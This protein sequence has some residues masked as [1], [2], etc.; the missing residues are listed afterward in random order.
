MVVVVYAGT[1]TVG[2][3]VVEGSELDVTGGGGGGCGFAVDVDGGGGAAR[4]PI[5]AEATTQ[6]DATVKRISSESYCGE[7]NKLLAFIKLLKHR[8]PIR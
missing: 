7:H 1:D 6:M 5:A 3:G 8:N 2:T 4:A